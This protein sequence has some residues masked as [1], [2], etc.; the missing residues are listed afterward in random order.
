MWF[1]VACDILSVPVSPVQIGLNGSEGTHFTQQRCQAEAGLA[2][3][4]P[5]PSER[6]AARTFTVASSISAVEPAISF[7]LCEMA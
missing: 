1:D 4:C 5:Q 7:M 2:N 3:G 6:E